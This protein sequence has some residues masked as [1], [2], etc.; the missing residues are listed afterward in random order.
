MEGKPKQ[1]SRGAKNRALPSPTRSLRNTPF[2]P[3]ARKLL[4]LPETDA[5]FVMHWRGKLNFL[6]LPNLTDA[7]II[8]F[9]FDCVRLNNIG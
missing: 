6:C 8:F 5:I 1:A 9:S 2:P 3:P 7:Y 4:S